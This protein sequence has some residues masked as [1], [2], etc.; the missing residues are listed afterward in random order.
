VDLLKID[1][2]FLVGPGDRRGA[3][4][5]AIVQLGRV[6]GLPTIVEVVETAEQFALVARIGATA[7]QGYLLCRPLPADD[8]SPW[9]RAQ[10]ERRRPEPQRRLRR[11]PGQPA[12]RR[13]RRP[14][15]P[16][17]SPD[18]ARLMVTA[19][20]PRL[21]LVGASRPG[22]PTRNLAEAGALRRLDRDAPDADQTC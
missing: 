14:S 20:Q 7:A 11:L 12:R 10:G 4:L 1:R 17:R 5:P 15:Y 8:V 16:R 21:A 18:G 19:R 22:P 2:A 3:I 6:L 13:R 9:L